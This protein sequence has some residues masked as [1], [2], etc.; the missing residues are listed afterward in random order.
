[1]GVCLGVRGCIGLYSTHT[2]THT[3]THTRTHTHTHTH[4]HA[5]THTHTRMHTRTHTQH[6]HTRTA[7]TLVVYTM[8]EEE[9]RECVSQRFQTGRFTT[10][11]QVQQQV[12]E[13]L[14]LPQESTTIFSIWLASKHLRKTPLFVCIHRLLSIKPTCMCTCVSGQ[15]TNGDY[16]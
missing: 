7:I 13:G 4:T 1:M 11:E 8:K 12:M 15:V 9:V 10:A 14:G 3:H 6:T 16:Y 2:H 5:H